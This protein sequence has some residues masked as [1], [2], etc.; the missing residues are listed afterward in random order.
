MP[1]GS[2]QRVVLVNDKAAPYG[3]SAESS[4]RHGKNRMGLWFHIVAAVFALKMPA[5]RGHLAFQAPMSGLFTSKRVRA[6]H[7]FAKANK[8][9][10]CWV[11]FLKPR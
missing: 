10:S 2:Q 9:C 1:I 8:V 11:F 6:I 4:L 7:K 3:T 5:L